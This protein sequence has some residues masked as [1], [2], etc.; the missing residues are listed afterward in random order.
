MTAE[1]DR[2]GFG[3]RALVRDASRSA[4]LPAGVEPVVGDL[5][6]P[7]TLATAVDGVDAV[8]FTHGTYGGESVIERVPYGTS[9]APATAPSRATDRAGPRNRPHLSG[10]RSQRRSSSWPS[11]ARR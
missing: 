6:R 2:Q 9:A 4:Q 1:A 5:A 11:R 3:I 8:V 7:E 10:G